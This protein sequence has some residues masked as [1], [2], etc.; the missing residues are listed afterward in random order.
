VAKRSFVS[1]LNSSLKKVFL[2]ILIFVEKRWQNR[3]ANFTS[4]LGLR[5]SSRM[6]QSFS[7]SFWVDVQFWR[8][9]LTKKAFRWQKGVA[10]Y[11]TKKE[12]FINAKK[13]IVRYFLKRFL[14]PKYCLI[15]SL[16]G[17]KSKGLCVQSYT[18][19][20]IFDLGLIQLYKK[21]WNDLSWDQ[22]IISQFF[23]IF[24]ML[25]QWRPGHLFGDIDNDLKKF[26]L[27]CL[28]NISYWKKTV[29]KKVLSNS[30]A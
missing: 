19:T 26:D 4:G 5:N 12:F 28:M 17:W 13:K 7:L 23:D 2:F 24:L 11:K 18:F 21:R 27:S 14:L 8:E 3:L 20:A 10:V 25:R 29:Q 16:S 6:K 22:S 30:L 15:K 9:W 1:K